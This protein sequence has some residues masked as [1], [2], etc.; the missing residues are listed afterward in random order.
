MFGMLDRVHADAVAEQRAAGLAPR[1][2][3]RDDRDLQRVVLVE[4]EAAHELVGERALAGAAGAGDAERRA[5]STSPRRQCSS[6][7][8]LSGTA[9][10][11]SPVMRRASACVRAKRAPSR[12]A[13]SDAGKS[14]A[15]STSHAATISLIMPCRPSRWPSSGEKMRVDAVVVQLLDL[16]R[17]DHAAAA[18]EH[19]DV[20]AAALAQQVDHVLEELDV[21]ALVRR[22]R[23]AVRVFLQRAVDDLLDRAVVAEV[24]HLAAGRLQDAAHDVDRRVVAVEQARRRDEAHLVDGL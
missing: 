3:D 16:G 18:A 1:R 10:F 14:V 11:S 4:A 15:R 5:P 19:L 8:S 7:R 13:S 12:S 2:I 24:D 22:D 21:A 20:A 17:H 23:D 6:P 9:P